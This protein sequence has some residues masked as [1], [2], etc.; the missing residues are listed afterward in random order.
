MPTSKKKRPVS[1]WCCPPSSRLKINCDGAFDIGSGS[2]RVVVVVRND[3][4][5]FMGAVCQFVLR[6]SDY[7][8]LIRAMERIEEDSSDVGQILEDCRTYLSSIPSIEFHHIYR[9]TNG[10]AHR[11]AHFT[12]SRQENLFVYMSL[13][14]LF[15]MHS[16]KNNVLVHLNKFFGHCS[17]PFKKKNQNTK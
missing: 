3:S 10:V 14:L 17:L 1:K 6:E 4:G 7:A 11:L 16:S 2:D 15:R 13:L 12:N 5:G 9:E 8:L